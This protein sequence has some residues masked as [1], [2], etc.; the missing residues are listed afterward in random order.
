MGLAGEAEL[1]RI[2][3][4]PGEVPDGRGNN[5]GRMGQAPR[6]P[7]GLVVKTAEPASADAAMLAESC[8]GRMLHPE[9]ERVRP[10]EVKCQQPSTEQEDRRCMAATKRTRIFKK[11]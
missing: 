2:H 5:A 4:H 11:I 10:A 3:S 8:R 9:E 7:R 6:S 1:M